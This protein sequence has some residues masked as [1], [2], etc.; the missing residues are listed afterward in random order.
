MQI[1]KTMIYAATQKLARTPTPHN[2]RPQPH[3]NEQQNQQPV[4][5]WSAKTHEV[6]SDLLQ[7][8]Q[9]FKQ[10]SSS[11]AF[12]SKMLNKHNVK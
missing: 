7:R 12:Q 6:V 10:E 2:Q 3:I 4:N 11:K 9:M 5:Q 1:E 8:S